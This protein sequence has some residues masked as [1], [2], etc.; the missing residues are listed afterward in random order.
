[1]FVPGLGNVRMSKKRWFG[2]LGFTPLPRI[3]VITKKRHR[4]SQF[5]PCFLVLYFSL[6]FLMRVLSKKTFYQSYKADFFFFLFS[7][8][9]LL[10]FY[11]LLFFL[12]LPFSW[13]LSRWS[14]RQDVNENSRVEKG[15]WR[16]GL[17]SFSKD[18]SIFFRRI[19]RQNGS[20]KIT[21]R[22]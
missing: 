1:M 12:F 6:F 7:F 2:F 3:G 19:E 16:W 15:R 11:L 4:Q 9:F 13:G 20:W 10:L 22:M 8:S 5:L 21:Q 14:Q 17:H 18:F